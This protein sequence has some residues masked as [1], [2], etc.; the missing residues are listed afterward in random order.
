ML[1]KIYDNVVKEI[2]EKRYNF[3]KDIVKDIFQEIMNEFQENKLES[4]EQIFARFE[5]IKQKYKHDTR[6]Y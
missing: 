2:N 5:E 4:F 3:V 1:T 6:I